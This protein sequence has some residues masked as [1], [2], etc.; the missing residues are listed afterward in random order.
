MIVTAFVLGM[1][2]SGLTL[3]IVRQRDYATDDKFGSAIAS[4]AAWCAFGM[5]LIAGMYALGL[6]IPAVTGA[7]VLTV[8]RFDFGGRL[9]PVADY[10]LPLGVGAV[11]CSVLTWIGILNLLEDLPN[12]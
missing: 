3:A 12:G 4:F 1:C 10:K 11:L 6:V 8:M 2:L 9:W 7:A 5:L